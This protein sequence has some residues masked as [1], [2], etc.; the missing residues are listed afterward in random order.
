MISDD[1]IRIPWC[2]IP[3]QQHYDTIGRLKQDMH[4][5]LH[6]RSSEFETGPFAP[7]TDKF[8]IIQASGN[9]YIL[10]PTASDYAFLFRGQNAFYKDCAP[11]LYRR[12]KT[13]GE[14]FEQRLKCAEFQLMAEELPA[15]Q[16]FRQQKF[17]IDYLGLAQHYGLQTD[18]LD[19]TVDPDIAL[20]FAM[21]DYD[22]RN[23][24][25][26]AKSQEREYIGYLYAINVFSYT[27]YSPKKLE[28]L[29]TS[30]LKA[31]G[32]Q[33][34]D[35][36]GNQKAFSLHLDEGEKLKANLYS[37]ITR[38]RIRRNTV[39]NTL[40]CGDRTCYR[41]E[42]NQSVIQKSTRTRL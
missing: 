15:V 30:K 12:R 22:P 10:L 8:E 5:Y 4:R 25:Y 19:L 36:P 31:I 21:C 34:F 24:R 32:L 23:D 38:S 41:N 18:I 16:Y 37:S 11:T 1:L 27:D 35:R 39:G 14:I 20:F 7:P 6:A 42:R 26:T 33:P 13:P 9:S 2:S 29:F 40:I 28:N 17:S 3:P